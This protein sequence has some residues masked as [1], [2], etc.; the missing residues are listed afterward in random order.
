MSRYRITEV[1]EITFRAEIFERW[2]MSSSVMPSEKYSWAGSP[3]RFVRGR[4]ARERMDDPRGPGP[5]HFELNPPA[6][7]SSSAATSAT[8]AA[9]AATAIRCRFSHPT[10]LGGTGAVPPEVETAWRASTTSWA[11]EIRSSGRFSRHRRTVETRAGGIAG[12]RGSGS[13]ARI[14]VSTSA[15]V[16]PWKALLPASAS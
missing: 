3:E 15:W 8:T 5:N 1:R 12:G 10:G 14:A 2:V 13:L 6:S 7:S 16:S 4:T 11:E 9:P